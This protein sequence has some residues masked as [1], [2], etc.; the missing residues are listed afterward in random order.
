MMSI[1]IDGFLGKRLYAMSPATRFEAKLSMHLCL[2]CSIW[3][4]FLSSSLTVST[5]AL[6]LSRILSCRFMR[7]FFMFFLSLVTRCM[8][9]TKRVSNSSPTGE[10]LVLQG[11]TVVHVP[12][13]ERPLYDFPA[14]VYDD[15]QLEAV[16]PSHGAFAPGR[17]SPHG[18][19]AVGTLYVA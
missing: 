11:F 18:L 13:R 2:V 15:V 7:E 8:S 12:R 17:P 6:F 19:V 10:V 3:Q 16:E 4:T 9:S 14:V 1:F 5:S